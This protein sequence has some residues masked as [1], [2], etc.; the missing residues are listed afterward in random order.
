VVNIDEYTVRPCSPDDIP[1]I[2]ALARADEERISG[3]PSR[4]NEDDFTEWWQSV[5][6]T[7]SSWL[8]LQRDAGVP[9]AATWL[10]RQGSDLVVT[11]PV[12]PTADT[13]PVMLDLAEEGARELGQRR[14]HVALPEPD[15]EPR[16]VLSRR[17]YREIRRFLHMAVAVSAPPP[18]PALPAGLTLQPVT[19][20]GASAFHA[21]LSEAFA[22]HWEFHPETFDA[23]WDRVSNAPGFDLDW[24][25]TVRDGHEV[26]A[27]LR[28]LPGRD[29]GVYVAALGVRRPWRGRGLARALLLHTFARAREAGIER[30][31]LNVDAT[32]P[33]GATALYRSV[34]MSVEFE[35]SVWE[36]DITPAAQ[37]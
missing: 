15:P 6:L 18:A 34:G 36:T 7:R 12:A 1:A 11:F 30:V 9:V 20:Q 37:G 32:N 19:S 21:A 14:L 13:L 25:F 24:W 23:W 3:R 10:E 27:V 22:D 28:S 29:D 4:L 33:T 5:D 8:L 31:S 26:A 17:D 2:L 35:N 16:Q